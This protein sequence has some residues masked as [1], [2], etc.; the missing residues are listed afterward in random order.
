MSSRNKSTS[1]VP[2]EV[3]GIETPAKRT[4]T[5]SP[6]AIT[7][8]LDEEVFKAFEAQAKED[9]RELNKFIARKLK[10]LYNSEKP[11]TGASLNQYAEAAA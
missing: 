2:E 10:A 8:T 11:Y 9:D 6:Y 4:R 3:E 5:R 7:I 1:F